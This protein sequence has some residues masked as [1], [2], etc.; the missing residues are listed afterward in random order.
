MLPWKLDELEDDDDDDLAVV[1]VVEE[2]PPPIPRVLR[3]PEIK[4]VI[5]LVAEEDDEVVAVEP[6]EDVVETL[7]SASE[8]LL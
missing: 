5:P 7:L 2:E 4:S 6:E 1:V 8:I 3:R